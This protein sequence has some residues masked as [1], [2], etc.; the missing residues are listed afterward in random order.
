MQHLILHKPDWAAGSFDFEVINEEIETA[1]RINLFDN[2]SHAKKVSHQPA[3]L[4]KQDTEK[5][6]RIDSI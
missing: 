3:L 6:G 1:Q 4:R 2:F 5:V